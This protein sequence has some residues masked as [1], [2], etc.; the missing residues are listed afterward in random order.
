M[1]NSEVDGSKYDH[2]WPKRSE[3]TLW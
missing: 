1:T 3:E 2:S